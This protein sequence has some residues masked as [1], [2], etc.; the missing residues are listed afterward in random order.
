MRKLTKDNFWLLASLLLV[1]IFLSNLAQAEGIRSDWAEQSYCEQADAWQICSMSQVKG[2][3]IQ[4]DG[5]HQ[6]I[7]MT[8][9]ENQDIHIS[10]YQSAALSQGTETS[11]LER[12]YASDFGIALNKEYRD[13]G[14]Q[15][16]LQRDRLNPDSVRPL[17]FLGINNRW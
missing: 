10:L 14:L 2:F 17:L 9:L 8:Y 15:L 7:E 4:G 1:G 5:F 12:R 11:L 16:Q 13:F 6:V 3:G